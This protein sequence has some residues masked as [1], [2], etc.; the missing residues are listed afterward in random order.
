MPAV[1]GPFWAVVVVTGAGGGPAGFCWAPGAPD[2]P[3]CP[4][5]PHA[6]NRSSRVTSPGKAAVFDIGRRIK[7]TSKPRLGLLTRTIATK[8]QE[9]RLTLFRTHGQLG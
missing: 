6:D 9:G 7:E 3:L 1:M 8:F 5:T 2:A 4:G